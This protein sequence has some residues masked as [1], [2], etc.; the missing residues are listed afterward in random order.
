MSISYTFQHKSI[1]GIVLLLPLLL[2]GCA[3]EPLAQPSVCVAASDCPGP[4]DE[5]QKRTCVN[6]V[7]GIDHVAAGTLMSQ[8]TP[9]DCRIR[10]CDGEGAAVESGDDTD[11]PPDDG[12]VCATIACKDGML[13]VTD[14]D[15][16]QCDDG[17][18]CTAPDLCQK[19][20]CRGFGEALCLFGA[21]C[22]DGAC[23]ASACPGSLWLPGPPWARM[24]PDPNGAPPGPIVPANINGDPFVDFAIANSMGIDVFIGKGNGLFETVKH[25]N[26]GSPVLGATVADFDGD[27]LADLAAACYPDS[28]YVVMG[29]GTG[30]FG[31]GA[32]YPVQNV[33]SSIATSDLN[34]DGKFDLAITNRSSDSVSVLLNTGNGSFPNA[35]HYGTSDW[36]DN[37][38]L[39]DIFLDGRPSMVVVNRGVDNLSYG[40]NIFRN[41]GDGTF[42]KWG[43]GAAQFPGYSVAVGQLNADGLP[44]LLLSGNLRVKAFLNTGDSFI[45]GVES[46]ADPRATAAVVADLNGDGRDDVAYRGIQ[47]IS[48]MLRLDS[49]AFFEAGHY[50]VA[51]CHSFPCPFAAADLTGDGKPE[52]LVGQ[53]MMGHVNVLVNDGLGNF[54]APLVVREG[55]AITDVSIADLN[56]DLRTD[57]VITDDLS[58]TVS[59]ML[60]DS[61]VILMNPTSYAVGP[62]GSHSTA[63][64]ELNGDRRPDL[65]VTNRNNHDVSVLLNQGNGTFG[66]ALH[67]PAVTGPVAVTGADVNGDGLADLVVVGQNGVG[68]LIHQANST[69]APAVVIPKSEGADSVAAADLN[70]DGK[71]DLAVGRTS[72]NSVIS[73]F[74]NA[75]DG[76]YAEP[77]D[78]ALGNQQKYVQIADL[79]GDNKPDLVAQTALDIIVLLNQGDG[80]FPVEK[81]YLTNRNLSAMAVVD[82]NNDG[83]PDVAATNLGRGV[84]VLMNMGDGQLDAPVEFALGE[85]PASLRGAD[86]NRDGRPDLV[87]V[88][89]GVSFEKR[90][91]ILYNSCQP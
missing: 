27:G 70:G 21:T 39:A 18:A 20:V 24:T 66:Q 8:Q 80:T 86:M 11:V 45:E 43:D 91:S 35:T 77:K 31:A 37:V 15:G 82:L 63:I 40:M 4:E 54:I 60:G 33:P 62:F 3:T 44:D 36:P 34:A 10:V 9:G 28:A 2:G 65:V 89:E 67:Y 74:I 56:G 83:K 46:S 53:S 58:N 55:M 42:A 84:A 30:L 16:I 22:K 69:F 14:L 73:V 32:F 68:V 29:Q 17:D 87:A 90:I 88:T 81:H 23:V 72:T 75:G 48:V 47:T 26:V 5:C 76:A 59:V 50:D 19:S 12:N 41:N 49:G 52:L 1:S 61:Q 6:G 64:V 79:D 25:H 85:H 51:E 78:F 71:M 7:C 13:L 57:V 38:V